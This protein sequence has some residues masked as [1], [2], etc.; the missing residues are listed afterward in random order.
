MA[1]AEN[2]S[3]GREAMENPRP[4]NSTNKPPS[5]LSWWIRR[6]IGHAPRAHLKRTLHQEPSIKTEDLFFEE[7]SIFEKMPIILENFWQFS[8]E[9]TLYSGPNLFSITSGS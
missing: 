7:I 1:S 4:R 8:C 5:T 2:F 6:C 3:G 9:K